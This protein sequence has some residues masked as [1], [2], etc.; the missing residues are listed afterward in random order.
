MQLSFAELGNKIQVF[1]N[2]SLKNSLTTLET[3]MMAFK[4]RVDQYNKEIK[5]SREQILIKD[6]QPYENNIKLI[7][8][9]I[10]DMDKQ[11]KKHAVEARK[12]VNHFEESQ[13]KSIEELGK[14]P[15]VNMFEIAV[16]LVQEIHNLTEDL[17][18]YGKLFLGLY[19]EVLLIE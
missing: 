4:I 14:R 6:L 13:K 16:N 15:S 7:Y 2:G 8:V 18:L 19:Q 12:K 1:Q 10:T 9:Q 5:D 3:E 17:K 11:L